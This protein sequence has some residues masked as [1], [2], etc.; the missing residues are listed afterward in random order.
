MKDRPYLFLELSTAL[1]VHCLDRVEAKIIEQDG[2]IFM[3]KRCLK[4]GVEKVLIA[5]DP[6][7]YRLCRETLKPGQ[8]PRRFGTTIERGCPYDCGLCP[9]HEQHSCLTVLEVTDGCNLSCPVCYAESGPTK[10]DTHRPLSLIE[11][12]L[13]QIV[14]SEGEPDVVQ[15]SGGEPTIHPQFWEILDAA[16]KRPIKHLMINTNG[17]KI[18]ADPAFAERL[19]TYMPGFEVYL[20]WDSFEADTLIRLRGKDLRDIRQRALDNLN[21][22]GVSTTLVVTLG[23]GLNDHEVGK[24]IEFALKQPC[25]RGVTFQPIQFAGRSDSFDPSKDRLTL[26]E[27]RQ[28]IL[29]QSATFKPQDIIPVPCHPDSL[30]MAYALKLNGAVIPL[31]GLVDPQELLHSPGNTIIYEKNDAL[32]ARL[33]ELFST[34]A[35][36]SGSATSLKQLLC[37]LPETEVPDSLGYDSIFRVIIMKFMDAHDMDIRSVKK[38]CVH[39]AS[40][41]GKQIPFD[42]YNIFYRDGSS[43]EKMLVEMTPPKAAKAESKE[44]DAI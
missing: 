25:V 34:A 36:P 42:T 41:D 27:V 26:S 11:K 33:F 19:A 10:L 35:N 29:A 39:I 9:D 12:M 28:M 17:I 16:K 22:A 8:L 21:L 15:I 2:K 40:P 18:A 37:C 24:T 6:A 5:S 38:S 31:T 14:H 23:K 3:L 7:Y 20:Q 30:A 44:A 4:H 1:C 13:D 32:R 43:G